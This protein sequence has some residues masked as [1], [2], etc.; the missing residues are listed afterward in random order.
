MWLRVK[1]VSQKYTRERIVTSPRNN[2]YANKQQCYF[3][4]TFLALICLNPVCALAHKMRKTEKQDPLFIHSLRS[5]QLYEAQSLRRSRDFFQLSHEIIQYLRL[6]LILA[7]PLNT[8][9]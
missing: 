4:R 5:I 9:V 2:G 3:I 1:P 8:R 6:A 7:V